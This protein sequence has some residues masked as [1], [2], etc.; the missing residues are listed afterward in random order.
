ML[1]LASNAKKRG[2]AKAALDWYEQAYNAA[3]GP[4]TRLQWGSTYISGLL[5]LAPDD[6]KRIEKAANSVIAE[7][8]ETQNAFYE[9]NRTALEKLGHKFQVWNAAGRHDAV[10]QQV[11]RQLNGVC[12]KL[13][14]A[15]PQRAACEGVLETAKS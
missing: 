5:E 8:G 3:K 7:L 6:E 2:D 10:F 9:R 14:A 15:D 11:R 4:A 13:P 12:A 1:S